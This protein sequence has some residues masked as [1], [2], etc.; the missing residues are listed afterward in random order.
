MGHL[1][2]HTKS[3]PIALTVPITVASTF[4]ARKIV[5]ALNTEKRSD[6]IMIITCKSDMADK[7]DLD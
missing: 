7:M 6:N 3:V 4:E 2:K 1:L 5:P